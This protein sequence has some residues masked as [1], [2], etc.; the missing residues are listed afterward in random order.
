V[1]AVAEGH[2][3][4]TVMEEEEKILKS[5]PAEKEEHTVEFLT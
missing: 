4:E 2:Q 5:T 1:D 3:F